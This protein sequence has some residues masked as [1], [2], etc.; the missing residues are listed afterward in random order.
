MAKHGPTA[1][2]RCALW[3]IAASS[4]RMRTSDAFSPIQSLLAR[5]R[6]ES[7]DRYHIRPDRALT[8]AGF[9]PPMDGP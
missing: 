3:L 6:Y 8:M 4:L 9:P 7:A 1:A 2:G 5:R